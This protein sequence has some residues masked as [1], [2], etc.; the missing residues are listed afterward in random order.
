MDK[1]AS[2]NRSAHAFLVA[3]IFAAVI[4]V[5]SCGGSG[6]RNPPPPVST[7]IPSVPLTLG[8]QI[9]LGYGLI[10]PYKLVPY[11]GVPNSM[12]VV[13]G[14]GET[15][16]EGKLH[17]VDADTL[18]DLREPVDIGLNGSDVV[19][20]GGQR[21]LVTSR[22]AQR[23]SMIDIGN[24]RK[25]YEL[26][27]HFAAGSIDSLTENRV[28][29]ASSA[30]GMVAIVEIIGDQL[31]ERKRVD[32]GTLSYDV[33]VDPVRDCVYVIQPL[34]GVHI[35]AASDLS[36][37]GHVRLPGEP[38]RGAAIWDRFLLVSNRD[39]YLHAIDAD[40]QSVVTLDLATEL[41]LD[42]NQLPERG[43]DP[44]EILVLD[45]NQVAVVNG[46]QPGL[47][48]RPL[49]GSAFPL[50]TIAR[51]PSGQSMA[52]FRDSRKLLTAQ[53]S[54]DRIVT[55]TVTDPPTVGGQL[56]ARSQQTGIEITS[57]LAMAEGSRR[58]AVLDSSGAISIIGDDAKVVRT[59]VASAGQ[60]WR[61]PLVVISGG[62]AVYGQDV[63]GHAALFMVD[64]VGVPQKTIPI[65]LNSVFSLASHGREIVAVGRLT[66]Q[67]QI[68]DIESGATQ[69]LTLQRSRP[70]IAIGL[71][72]SWA[73]AHDTFPDIGITLV[74][75]GIEQG[76][77]P[78]DDWFTQ[79]V[80][81]SDSQAIT[82]SFYG[83]VGRLDDSGHLSGVRRT[84]LLG[85]TD[86]QLGLP[87]SMWITSESLGVS[88]R[89]RVDALALDGKFEHPGMRSIL[90]FPGGDTFALI[91]AR[92]LRIAR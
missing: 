89:L 24:W 79:L 72:A 86:A 80:R 64:E 12:L 13:T 90:A 52:Y 49:A 4:S 10:S 84:G 50:S 19:V 11:D 62:F 35:L 53:S 55:V 59:I 28:V 8:L 33:V 73:I 17:L 14:R 21:A 91:S 22:G 74:R 88:Y 27:L 92:D 18:L 25:L 77:G 75:G 87:G 78:F 7:E 5:L 66:R 16:S 46:R 71:G 63:G 2:D 67:L 61:G 60:S 76:F 82:S 30:D 23:V 20:M 58:I 9:E 32:L 39:G 69:L 51:I 81:L 40:G 1:I 38:G 56:V 36:Y 48:L 70:R 42:R 26:D 47:L 54:I 37:R 85:A 83:A 44:G 3:A 41:G 6:G 57:W 31:V 15:F 34:E 29:I 43:I 45:A 68:V 65:A